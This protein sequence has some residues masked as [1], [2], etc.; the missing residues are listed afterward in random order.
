MQAGRRGKLQSKREGEEGGGWSRERKRREGIGTKVSGDFPP[1]E[2][3]TEQN[4]R[5]VTAGGTKIPNT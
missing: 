1:G 4:P 2:G 3:I 5:I